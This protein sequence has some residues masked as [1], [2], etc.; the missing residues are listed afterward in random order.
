MTMKIAVGSPNPVKV[1]AA[2]SVIERVW[3][4]ATIARVTVPSGVRLMPLSDAECL[5]GA[6]NGAAAAQQVAQAD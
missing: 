5:E 1:A 3:P 6:R 2:R 4:G